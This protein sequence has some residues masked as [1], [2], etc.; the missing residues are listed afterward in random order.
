MRKEVSNI[1]NFKKAELAF[2]ELVTTRQVLIEANF[3]PII[4]ELQ[5]F[6]DHR[7]ITAKLLSEHIKALV[8]WNK[9]TQI[10]RDAF[11]EELKRLSY[12]SEELRKLY[13][14]RAKIRRILAKQEKNK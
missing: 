4:R 5:H 2:E 6:N 12:T 14:D 10:A 11:R 7:S 9:Q 1:T 3:E 8:D 13:N